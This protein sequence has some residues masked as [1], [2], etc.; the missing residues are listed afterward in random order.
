MEEPKGD[1]RENVREFVQ[2]RDDVGVGWCLRVLYRLG[3]CH[4]IDY[5]HESSNIHISGGKETLT[6]RGSQTRKRCAKTAVKT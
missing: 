5:D 3:N 2:Q 1:Y 6:H 4:T